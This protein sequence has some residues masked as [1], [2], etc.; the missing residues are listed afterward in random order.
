MSTDPRAGVSRKWI[1]SGSK[2]GV[3]LLLLPTALTGRGHTLV[4]D[5]GVALDFLDRRG[6]IPHQ[7]RPDLTAL[8]R[9]SSVAGSSFGL[10]HDVPEPGPAPAARKQMARSSLEPEEVRWA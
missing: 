7:S 3:W 10:V 6:V 2:H 5:A 8:R 9:V 4:F 1:C